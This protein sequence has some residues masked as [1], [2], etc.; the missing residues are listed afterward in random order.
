MK[1]FLILFFIGLTFVVSAQQVDYNDNGKYIA[2]GYDVV[3]YFS[4]KALIGDTKH[5]HSHNGTKFKFANQANLDT[6]K[7][8]PEKYIPQYGGFCAY[9]L[10]AKNIKKTVDPESFEIR[11]G[12]LYLFYTYIFGN[13]LDDWKEGDTNKLK[14]QADKNWEKLKT[15][16]N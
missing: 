13:K 5:E 8:N 11:D 1:Q 12:K 6:F 4:G 10:G 9:A 3:A 14:K 16:K 7:S 15:K 2:K